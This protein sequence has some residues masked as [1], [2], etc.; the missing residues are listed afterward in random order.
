MCWCAALVGRVHDGVAHEQEP[1]GLA[2]LLVLGLRE[3]V[4][5]TQHGELRCFVPR[6]RGGLLGHG[7]LPLHPTL[8]LPIYGAPARMTTPR[9]SS[10]GA[11]GFRLMGLEEAQ[12][13]LVDAPEGWP[14]LELSHAN[15]PRRPDYERVTPEEALVWLPGEAWAEVGRAS[16]HACLHMPEPVSAAAL[17]HP[18][19]APVAL[20]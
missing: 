13:L 8:R 9:R 17:V 11:Y 15:G 16:M 3:R 2:V 14:L 12:P 19:L 7:Y 18:Y 6:G 4:H 10:S 5:A 20:V 1:I